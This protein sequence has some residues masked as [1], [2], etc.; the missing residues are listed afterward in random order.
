M[1]FNLMTLLLFLATALSGY[2]D[3]VIYIDVAHFIP[4]DSQFGVE[5]KG[6]KWIFVH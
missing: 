3:M 2:T 1:K 5:V 6:N 4:A